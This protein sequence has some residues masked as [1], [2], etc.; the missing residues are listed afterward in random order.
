MHVGD[1]QVQQD[2]SQQPGLLE[3]A[4]PE[5]SEMATRRKRVQSSP[6][7]ESSVEAVSDG[8]EVIDLTQD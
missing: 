8:G 4:A 3:E 1:E 6:E 5:A 2:H 7:L